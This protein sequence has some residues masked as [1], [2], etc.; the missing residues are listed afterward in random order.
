MEWDKNVPE[1]S[2]NF[3]DRVV[4]ASRSLDQRRPVTLRGLWE[5]AAAAL[6]LRPNWMLATMAAVFVI[7]LAVGV[8]TYTIADTGVAEI[9]SIDK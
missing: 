9:M 2:A 7:G 1:M 4:E 8:E 6:P 5:R 3:C